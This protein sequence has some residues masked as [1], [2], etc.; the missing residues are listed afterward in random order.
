MSKTVSDAQRPQEL[1]F[2]ATTPCELAVLLLEEARAQMSEYYFWHPEFGWL[3]S[4][5]GEPWTPAPW[6]TN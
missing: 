3:S 6:W 5:T 1:I 4:V 2:P